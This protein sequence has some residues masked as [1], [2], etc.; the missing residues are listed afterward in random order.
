MTNGFSKHMFALLAFAIVAI[1]PSGTRADDPPV[2]PLQAVAV[3]APVDDARLLNAASDDGSLMYRRS[4][5]SQGYAP[6]D[7]IDTGNV[8]KLGLAFSYATGLPQGH[9]AAPIVNGRTMYITTPLDHVVALDATDGHV[10]WTYVHKVPPKTLNSVC[11]DVVNRGVA[12]YGDLVYVATLDNRIVA[13]DA[14]TG[15]VVWDRMLAPFGVGYAMTSAPLVVHGLVIAG[16]SGGEYGARGFITALDA[17]TGEDRWKLF[18]VPAAGEP[19]SATW[20]AAALPRGGGGPWLTG[21]YDPKLDTLYWGVGNPGPWRAD[22][23]RGKNLYT[24]S[25]LALDP[26]TGHMKWYFQFTPNDEWDYDGVNEN[27][28]V[29][30][31]HRGRPIHA[32]FHA[33]R[34]GQFVVLDRTNG[35]LVYAEPLV[36]TTAV[37]GYDPDG[38]ARVAEDSRLQATGSTTVCPSSI[39]GKNW[40]PTAYDPVRGL[41]FVPVSHMCMTSTASKIDERIGSAY[42]G[43]D[44]RLIPEPGSTGFGEVLALNVATGARVWSDPSKFPWNA[45]MLATKGGLVFSGSSDQRFI[46]FD[47]ATGHELWS[48]KT[49]SGIVGVPVSYRVDGKQYVAILAGWGGGV[50]IFGGPA[51]DIT[52]NVPRGGKLYVFALP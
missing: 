18:T 15:T 13:L 19:G 3:S 44:Q 10:L 46:A 40:W 23:R 26:R 27:V 22:V 8:A 36:K 31:T 2:P 51:A 43:I 48:Y 7:Q 34:N 50:S 49:D 32:L 11:C 35:K 12:I 9:E 21:S 29:D 47:S 45:G 30:I 37:L 33:D 14:H 6:F 20:P 38:T 52:Q 17:K 39:G 41:A 42:L 5:D 1:A 4:Y 25:L 16:I 24:D 28:L